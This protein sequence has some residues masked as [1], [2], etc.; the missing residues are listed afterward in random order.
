MR[1]IGVKIDHMDAE[2]LH[3]RMGTYM[4]A[5]MFKECLM[6]RAT[7]LVRMM[8]VNIEESLEMDS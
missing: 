5:N 3:I 7:I 8:V 6:V 2:K 1:A 4:K